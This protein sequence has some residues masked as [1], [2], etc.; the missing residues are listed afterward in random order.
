MSEDKKVSDTSDSSVPLFNSWNAWYI[1]VIVF[2]LI[3]IISIYLAFK[4][5]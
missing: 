2:N 3:V 5:I 4:S 1:L